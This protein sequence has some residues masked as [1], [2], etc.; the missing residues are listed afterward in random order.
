MN[1][2]LIKGTSLS[3]IDRKI[4]ELIKNEKFT[5]ALV[6]TYDLEEDS[7][8]LLMED[9][10]TISFLTPNKVI[11]GRNFSNNIL[12]SDVIS[13]LNKYLDNPN[14]N[15][16]LIFTANNL[17]TRKKIVKELIS[18]LTIINIENSVKELINSNLSDYEVENKVKN[19]LEEYYQNDIERLINE[20]T[21]LKIAFLDTKK[22]TYY[23]AVNF[24]IKNLNNN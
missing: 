7:I 9:A 14:S 24:L 16:L 4:D 15:V 11:I 13:V 2:Y 8:L 10:D 21:K 23:D 17:D 22:I 18:K 19:L 5:E 6:T 1:S 3:L 12:S 20:I